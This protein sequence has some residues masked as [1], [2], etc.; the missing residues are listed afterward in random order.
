MDPGPSLS[1]NGFSVHLLLPHY[2][3]ISTLGARRARLYI[4]LFCFS[5]SKR[6]DFNGATASQ[7]M[8]LQKKRWPNAP[9]G[10]QQQGGGG[11]GGRG[12][13]PVS[14]RARTC[15]VNTCGLFHIQPMHHGGHLC[16]SGCSIIYL[17]PGPSFFLPLSPVPTST[18]AFDSHL[19]SRGNLVS[20]TT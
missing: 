3:Y 1:L 13:G 9:P 2:S 18:W 15:T 20:A 10:S 4:Y 19:S 11:G 8:A 7:K 5:G 17:L 14:L 6:A 16:L 12:E